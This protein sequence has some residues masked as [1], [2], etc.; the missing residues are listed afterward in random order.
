MDANPT[1]IKLH[2]YRAVLKIKPRDPSALKE[3][4]S[5]AETSAEIPLVERVNIVLT[6]GKHCR[7]DKFMREVAWE[8]AERASKSKL[9]VHA[10]ALYQVYFDRIPEKA[11]GERFLASFY[12]RE[13]IYNNPEHAYSDVDCQNLAISDATI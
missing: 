13:A 4:L 5:I 6:Y 3:M 7:D 10:A 9:Y 8:V 2:V 12:M 11:F 1:P